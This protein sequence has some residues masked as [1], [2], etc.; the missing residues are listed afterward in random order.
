MQ[1]KVLVL[2][3]NGQL[4]LSL[5]DI[6][7]SDNYLF[8]GRPEFDICNQDQLLNIITNFNPSLI[9]NCAAYTNVDKAEEEAELAYATNSEAV[10]NL[11]L[12]CGQKDIILIHIS[13]DYVFDGYK[14]V[15]YNELDIPNPLSIYGKSKYLGEEHIKNSLAKYIIIRTS[16]VFSPYGHNFFKTMIRLANEKDE[17]K[18][19]DDQRGGPTSAHN[20]AQVV[21]YIAEK[22]LEDKQIKYGIYNYCDSPNVS[23]YEF[24][25]KIIELWSIKHHKKMPNIIPILTAEYPNKTVR[26]LNS[27]LDCTLIKDIFGIDQRKWSQKLENYLDIWNNINIR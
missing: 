1:N 26:P 15:A 20:L 4:A 3:S 18:I 6:I 2:G 14:E 17:L 11:A 8:V 9:I 22:I 7:V 10:K 13:T 21:K 16:W 24:A 19:I 12:I 25:S 23:W 27:I 5:K